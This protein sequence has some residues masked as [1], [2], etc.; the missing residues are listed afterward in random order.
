MCT[1][2]L[3]T[4][5][6]YGYMGVIVDSSLRH[7]HFAWLHRR[8]TLIAPVRHTHFEFFI[9]RAQK[10]NVM[11]VTGKYKNS[12]CDNKNKG[13][14]CKRNRGSSG[15]VTDSPM[16][17]VD[18]YCPTGYFDVGKRPCDLLRLSDVPLQQPVDVGSE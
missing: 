2:P 14:I 7:P 3:D 10:D 1:A 12:H 15:P 13:F 18:G 4:L 9:G 17:A 6:L 8:E 16:P 11:N 5:T